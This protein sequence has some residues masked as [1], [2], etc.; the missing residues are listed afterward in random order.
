MFRTIA[1]LDYETF[2]EFFFRVHVRD[3]GQPPMSADSPAEVVIK[4]SQLLSFYCVTNH[5]RPIFINAI[6][7]AISSCI[8]PVLGD[9]HQ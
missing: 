7:D 5:F 4:A 6:L 8:H 9:Q 1:I 3:S 2:P